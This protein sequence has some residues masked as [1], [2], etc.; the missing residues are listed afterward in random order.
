[1]VTEVNKDTENVNVPL[2]GS[3]CKP[4]STSPF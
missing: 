1:M 2:G 4:T 3:I